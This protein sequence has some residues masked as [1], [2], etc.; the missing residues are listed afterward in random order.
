MLELKIGE[1]ILIKHYLYIHPLRSVILDFNENI[2]SIHLLK[3][4]VNLNFLVDDPVVITYENDKIVSILGGVVETIYATDRKLNIVV[5]NVTVEAQKR[6]YERFP[7]SLYADVTQKD[8]RGRD[9]VV[10]KDISEFGLQIFSKADYPLKTEL[11]IDIYMEK[12]VIFLRTTVV[13]KEARTNY[14]EY[15]LII[16]FDTPATMSY[17]KDY[18]D[19]LKKEQE[20]AINLIKYGEK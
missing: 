8:K 4:F 11:N 16:N 18:I 10:L 19:S 3:E 17:V 9:T 13:R 12:K 14:I 20:K 6:S 15:G 5:D 1:P 7:I 2:V